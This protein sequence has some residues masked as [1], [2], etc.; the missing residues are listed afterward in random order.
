[1]LRSNRLVYFAIPLT[2]ASL[3]FWATPLDR[4]SSEPLG[5]SVRAPV[6]TSDVKATSIAEATALAFVRNEGQ[7]P[8][9]V[10]YA[11]S[12]RGA[13]LRVTRGGFGLDLRTAE[14]TTVNAQESIGRSFE[15]TIKQSESSIDFR[16]VAARSS[17]EVSARE[18]VAGVESFFLDPDPT[19]WKANLPR[20]GA[21]EF[22]GLYDGI[23]ARL[24]SRDGHPEY[25][26][27]LAAGA[28]LG[29]VEI[30][31][32]GARSMSIDADGALVLETPTATVRQP[33][34]I[35]FVRDASG[36]RRE[37][38]CAFAIRGDSRYGFSVPSWDGASALEIDPGLI[39][40]SHF[41]DELF[42]VA[43]DSSGAIYIA[44]VWGG[45]VA[46][47]DPTKPAGQQVVWSAS[48]G[49]VYNMFD[50]AIGPNG[51]VALTG[52]STGG[53]P[54]TP[55]AYDTTA[56]GSYDAFIVQFDPSLPTAAQLVFGTYLGGSGLEW[57]GYAIDVDSSG[58]IYVT[59]ATEST[60]F[61]TTAGAYDTSH[62]G[63][64]Q[65]GDSY[66][67]CF[68]PTLT[69]AQQ[70]VY[71][72]FIGGNGSDSASGILG[73]SVITVIF[74]TT[75]SNMVTTPNA[76]DTTAN[77]GWDV[78]I[79]RLDRSIPFGPLQ[80][81]YASYLGGS[82]DDGASVRST[83][84][85]TGSGVVTI[86]GETNSSNFPLTPG[87]YD[88]TNGGSGDMFLT[89]LDTSAA[90]AAQLVYSTF[91]GGSGR[92]YPSGL[93]VDAAGVVTMSG[94]SWTS[95]LLTTA[96]AVQPTYGGG[97]GDGY[98]LRL[99]PSALPADQ[100]I[101][102]TYLGG[103]SGDEPM[104]LILDAA[105][106]ALV[107]GR[108]YSSNFPITPTG[109][110][111]GSGFLAIIDLPS[112][113]PIMRLHNTLGSASQVAQ[114]VIGP[115]LLPTTNS[116]GL[117]VIGTPRFGPGLFGNAS[118]LGP[119]QSPQ[120]YGS[121]TVNGLFMVSNQTG[122]LNTEK[123]TIE[124]VFRMV[125]PPTMTT[126]AQL[127]LFEGWIA[128][129]PVLR[130]EVTDECQDGTSRLMFG[131]ASATPN[132]PMVYAMSNTDPFPGVDVAPDTHAWLHAAAV[133]DRSGIA[134]TND[135]LRLYVNDRLVAAST[136]IDWTA[137]SATTM[138][139]GGCTGFGEGHYFLDD[140]KVWNAAVTSFPQT[141][142]M[143]ILPTLDPT[144]YALT[145]GMAPPDHYL[146]NVFTFDPANATAPG[147]GW[148]AGLHIGFFEV[149]SQINF[150]A[151][152]YLN[153]STK[154]GTTHFLVPGIVGFTGV[155]VYSVTLV[156]DPALMD[157]EAFST[158][159][160]YTFP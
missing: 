97:D 146:L 18:P 108:T 66:A 94:K 4:R 25:D 148:F 41:G 27:L 149:M 153:Y 151:P 67:T 112:P 133:W 125:E 45:W 36:D 85:V 46:K 93:R 116:Q 110:T 107:V 57:G 21:V 77:G 126:Y 22:S 135:K 9:E 52:R 152:P 105:G 142:N 71:S 40:A 31:V 141:L 35:A 14:E 17:T 60:N 143:R 137:A 104:D 68:N 109:S 26:V 88:T 83:P 106:R 62:G 147:V 89:R 15:R 65:F 96:G 87:A 115:P 131:F 132:S 29:T 90:P 32:D 7:W 91:I 145:N 98:L 129:Q 128:D 136:A 61:P 127:V 42:S 69:G 59:G 159:I 23:D 38:A 123:G 19:T 101:Y 50:M 30:A 138:K 13:G 8:D 134:G 117:N 100:L 34:P 55:N 1:M 111:S 150:M 99:N 122:V 139:I 95:N 58:L 140:V 102:M 156:I 92:D 144:V 70:L 12:T 3:L 47:V 63:G 44:G 160:A 80:M 120:S 81:I 86:A 79:A 118:A 158:P 121:A 6:P 5:R 74:N 76:Y 103:S 54:T 157:V 11:A 155:T 10:L 2:M 48:F 28:D 78:F 33:A 37:I 49:G 82:G 51:R 114:S 64:G 72:T 119:A 130:L 84:Q 43:L 154:N 24:Y 16:F 113:G 124:V 53:I 39:Y 75:S 20:F 73:G 56:N